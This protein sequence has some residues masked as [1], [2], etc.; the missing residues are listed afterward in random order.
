MEMQSANHQELQ[1]KIELRLRTMR[2]LWMA[3]LLSIGVYYVF[4][5]FLHRSDDVRPNA[6]FSL[7]LLAIAVST[8]LISFPLKS[9]FLNRATEQQQVLL[10]QQGYILTWAIT[11]IAALMGLLDFFATNDRYYYILFLIAACG[12]LVHFPRREHVTNAFFKSSQ[13]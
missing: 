1:Q 2:T 8:I 12:Q 5:L 9:R 10:V 6:T 7:V 4:T 3:M 13:F 11:E